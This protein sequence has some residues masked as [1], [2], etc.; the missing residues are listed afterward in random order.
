MKKNVF[1][2][3]LVF[4]I[5]SLFLL[6]NRD[7]ITFSPWN[8][9]GVFAL[10][11]YASGNSSRTAVIENAEKSVLLLNPQGELID[12]VKAQPYTE[13]SFSVAK[14]VS[15]DE[16]NN[17]YIL[18]ANFSGISGDSVERILKYSGKGTFLEEIYT[19][20]YTN[21]DFIITKGKISGMTYFEDSLYL[22]RLENNGFRLE[23]ISA[24]QRGMVEELAFFDY[25][26]AFHDLVYF[27][28]NPATEQLAVTTKAGDLRQYNFTGLLT[29]EWSA[30]LGSAGL[31]WTVI[32]DKANNL[33]YTDILTGEI[34]ALNT[35][36][37]AKTL[38]YTTLK[39]NPCYRINYDDGTLWGTSGD[40]I[41]IK[42]EA[43]E[44]ETLTAYTYSSPLR[45]LRILLF[46]GVIL[47]ILTFIWLIFLFI[48]IVGK[49]HISILL[50]RIL[51]IEICIAFGA[52]IASF[53]IINEMNDR[54]NERLYNGLENVSRLI[55]NK[56][57]PN[58]LKSFVSPGQYN[59]ETYRHFSG[60]LRTLFAQSQFQGEQVY[61]IIWTV[62]DNM[63]YGM[64]DLENSIGLYYPFA[65]YTDTSEY[66]EVFDTGA[67]IHTVTTTSEG[68][69]L[70]TC[71]PLF[72]EEGAIL[73]LI[74]TGYNMDMVQKQTRAM[75]FHTLLIVIASAVIFSV[76]VIGCILLFK[77]R[78]K[79]KLKRVMK[80]PVS[81][82]R[83]ILGIMAVFVVL[84]SI[85]LWNKER[86]RLSPWINGE[87]IRYPTYTAGNDDRIVIIENA[88]KSVTVL[89]QEQVLLY[90][91]NANPR[92]EKSFSS[93]KFVEIDEENH[94]YV[95]DA[96]FGGAF[97]DNIERVLKYS[98]TGE[99]L[100]EIY[101][102]QYINEDFLI[103]KGKIIAMAYFEG[104][105]YLC[106]LGTT[107]FWL[108]RALTTQKDAAEEIA[109]FEY[110]KAASNLTYGHI[111]V[112]N[113]ILAI[114]TKAGAIKQYDFTGTLIYEQPAPEMMH[115]PWTVVSDNNN[116]LIYTDILTGEIIALNT[117]NHEQSLLYLSS[118][119]ENPYYR[120]NYVNETLFASPY[121]ESTS[122]IY[123]KEFLHKGEPV[124][125]RII[126]YTYGTSTLFVRRV[127]FVACILDLILL[128]VGIILS[129]PFLSKH[130]TSES[131]QKIL[132]VGLCI[133]FGAVITSI[134]IIRGMNAYY[135]EKTFNNLE[136]VSR[137]IA[138]SVDTQVL[139]ALKAPAQYDN[140]EY[141]R[142]QST[143]KKIF[144]QLQFTGERLYQTIW[145]E[146]DGIVYGMYD[147][148]NSWGVFFPFDV[149]TDDSYYKEVFESKQ[150]RHFSN[151][152]PE[153]IWV[154]TCGP[155]LDADG[156]V[157]ALIETGYDA[158]TAQE[159]TR[160]TVIQTLLIVAMVTIAFL[161]VM[162]EFILI[163]DGYKK[164]KLGITGKKS[165]LS[166]LN[167]FQKFI[168]FLAY[169]YRKDTNGN[170]EKQPPLFRP[171]ILRATVSLLVEAYK[172]NKG[173]DSEQQAF[174][175][176]LLRAITF[177]MFT[178]CNLATAILPMYTAQLYQP[179]FNLP[180]EF[181]ITLPFTADMSFAALALLV[182]PNIIQ[183]FG[184]KR[185]GLMA[186][187]FILIGN[188]L[189]FIAPNTIYLAIA[190]TFIGFSSGAMI[191]VLNTIIGA[192]QKIEDVNSGFA[193]FNASY[194]T[195]VNVG[196]VLGSILAQFFSYQT[197]YLF[198]SI[199][200]LMLPCILIFSIKSKL[201]QHIYDITY[202]K[203]EKGERF[204]LIKFIFKPVVLG[205]LFLVLLPYIASMSFTTYFS[206]IYGIAM[207][208]RESNIGQLMLLSGLFAILFG[209]SLCEY[210]SRKFKI[211]TIV[212][213]SLVLNMGAFYLFAFNS[214][215][216][217]LIIAIV[218]I[219]IA[220][221]FTLTNIQTYYAVLYNN[222]TV[223]SMKA[224]S[225]YSAV[226]NISMA[227]GPVV[228]SFIVANS[229]DQGIKIFATVL[230][231]CLVAFIL[232]SSLFKGNAEK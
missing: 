68:T 43:G 117:R 149:Y 206:P 159:K 160:N 218:I 15:L 41:L 50:K 91:L 188:M 190:Y 229:I 156:N 230:L 26:Q 143:L 102:Y 129:I 109:F 165:P 128:L 131:L 110:P 162:I 54:Y 61:Q 90:Q 208:L 27:H 70:F 155:I 212:I 130:R 209:T 124:F 113:R 211:K 114:T 34:S 72:N 55:A 207:G 216:I 166:D 28:I 133:V 163:L 73:G 138:D 19:Y 220:N 172:R 35:K 193:H 157:I 231:V 48:P 45:L 104:A 25:P 31:P 46:A 141:I 154:F 92:R 78:K 81:F 32:S 75:I 213:G 136:N 21:E 189:C 142:L 150:Y 98:E 122:V 202:I 151:A 74:E 118:E 119:D 23:R 221:I 175:P 185:I 94:L 18:D 223:S 181:V 63:V 24:A 126:D 214:S 135:N 228:F 205:T 42:H 106:R 217:M 66:K 105:L 176:E 127:L 59:T 62:R 161:L 53:G 79:N 200:A 3:L 199:T 152:T 225:I 195:G 87:L 71:G 57:D 179:L 226:E 192:Q 101:R 14:L 169:A 187:I 184:I 111:N 86:I 33:I 88:E 76:I 96:A 153:G 64:Y 137:L 116:N 222:T 29:Y 65:E 60:S 197:V 77:D 7:I 180:K 30:G 85:L 112:K 232:I 201:L 83:L 39:A 224:L 17:L 12:T 171:P 44:F 204:G 103:T 93:A 22:V 144:A 164:N 125:E 145:M 100:E 173:E 148:E 80:K 13:K 182:I 51:L 84:S 8:N 227:I 67:Y 203:N 121:D 52:I 58:L 5:V 194:L 196:V 183:K 139:S 47:D 97:K 10:P 186:A 11:T 120:I 108:E 168:P 20:Q 174:H 36:T 49:I 147:L 140:E 178:A 6:W 4:V 38:L 89:N 99:F 158:V 37:A 177:F 123:D 215:I 146:R 219:A 134:F 191:L 2:G 1:I 9:T 198:S 132:F 170:V 107:G 16:D 69:W 82:P 95:L 210:V 167:L 40:T 56:I 115:L